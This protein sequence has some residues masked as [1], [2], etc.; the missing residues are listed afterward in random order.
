VKRR[1]VKITGIGFV[2]PAGIGKEAFKKGILEPVSYVVPVKRFD[3][4]A[5]SFVASEVKGFRLG[6]YVDAAISK[7]L[8]RHTQ[9]ALAATMLALRDAGISN[10]EARRRSPLVVLGT[11]LIAHDLMNKTIAGVARG[12]PRQALAR[13]V[14]QAPGGA[15]GGSVLELLGSGRALYLQTAC[16]AGADAIGNAVSLVAAGETDL[17]ICGG[18]EAPIFDCPMYELKMAGLSPDTSDRPEQLCRPFDL[19]RTTGVIGEGACIVTLEPETSPRPGYAFISGYAFSSDENGTSC[20]GLSSAIRL[21]LANAGVRASDVDH[22]SAWG[23]GHRK[24]DAAE[25]LIL[26]QVF[27]NELEH[28][29]VASIKGAIGNPLGAAGA[30]Q[31]G[32]AALGIRDS[33]IPPTV[34]WKHPDPACRLDLSS[35]PRFMPIGTVLV[36]AH[37]LSGSNSSLL[38]RRCT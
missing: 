9:F 8:P 23:P 33:F 36:D 21:C 5:G 26:R 10:E 37:G 30:I 29:P 16:C 31:I 22:I 19:W 3:P 28:I 12:G 11:S 13:A 6:D 1:R 34:N 17:A 4:E 24:V 15:I 2:T 25:S 14:F 27:G 18:T 20:S 7:H 38:L 35:Q 32:C